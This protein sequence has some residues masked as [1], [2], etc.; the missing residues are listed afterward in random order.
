M[1]GDGPY[2]SLTINC[3]R[4]RGTDVYRLIESNNLEHVQTLEEIPLLI[5]S[6]MLEFVDFIADNRDAALVFFR[7]FANCYKTLL[8]SVRFD[9]SLTFIFR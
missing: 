2:L 9:K 7:A 8:S 6:N 4:T 1:N 3:A 5:V